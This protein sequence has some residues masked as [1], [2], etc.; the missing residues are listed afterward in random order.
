MS[1]F[2]SPQ[3]VLEILPGTDVAVTGAEWIRKDN[4]NGM[5]ICIG[6]EDTRCTLCYRAWW[7]EKDWQPLSGGLLSV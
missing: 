1:A 6:C 7:L 5:A 3:D 4:V 2:L